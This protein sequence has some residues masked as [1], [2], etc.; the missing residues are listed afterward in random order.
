[1]TQAFWKLSL[2]TS[3]DPIKRHNYDYLLGLYLT[4]DSIVANFSLVF[5]YTNEVLATR[6]YSF[7]SKGYN[8]QHIYFDDFLV[9]LWGLANGG[10]VEKN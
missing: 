3:P 9:R 1:M 2:G 8:M 7:L 5:S 10:Y 6:L 4:C